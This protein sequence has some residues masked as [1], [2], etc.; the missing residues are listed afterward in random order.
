MTT[1]CS[2]AK[3][4]DKEDMII[5]FVQKEDEINHPYKPIKVPKNMVYPKSKSWRPAPM[6]AFLS[7]ILP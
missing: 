2:K 6:R 1:Y 5:Y 3:V 7:Q 4:F